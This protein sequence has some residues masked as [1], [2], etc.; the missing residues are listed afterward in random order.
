M[1]TFKVG[2]WVSIT[3]S[4]DLR[5]TDWTPTHDCFC[6]KTGKIKDVYELNG[7]TLCDVIAYFQYGI[8]GSAPGNFYIH[9]LPDHLIHSDQYDAKLKMHREKAEKDLKEW[10]ELKRRKTDEALRSV[11]CPPPRETPEDT[12]K[13]LGEILSQ[14]EEWEEKTADMKPSK[15]FL[16]YSDEELDELLQKYANDLGIDSFVD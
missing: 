2:D 4:A 3:P 7:D 15:K 10:E 16:E 11:F 8:N 6:G 14:E 13:A 5:W 9:F 12:K 1:A